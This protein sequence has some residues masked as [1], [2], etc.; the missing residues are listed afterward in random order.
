MSTRLD[1]GR[2][3]SAPASWMAFAMRTLH[4]P[5]CVISRRRRE[6]A[7]NL[8]PGTRGVVVRR[9]AARVGQFDVHHHHQR[10][11]VDGAY[12]TATLIAADDD[13]L[14]KEGLFKRSLPGDAVRA[15]RNM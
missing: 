7:R 4:R 12:E 10:V 1:V 11:L 15:A 3:S 6:G 5:T 9:R 13:F 14:R 8:H 2:H